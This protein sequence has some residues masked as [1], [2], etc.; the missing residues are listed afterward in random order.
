MSEDVNDLFEG[1]QIMSPTEL[2]NAVKDS[3]N[4]D[5]YFSNDNNGMRQLLWSPGKMLQ[6]C[7]YIMI[8]LS[9]F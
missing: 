7:F 5:G 6:L 3:E 9:I 2:N 4:G 8:E 1:L